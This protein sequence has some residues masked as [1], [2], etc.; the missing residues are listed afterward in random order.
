MLDRKLIRKDPDRVR[1]GLRKKGVA[2]DLDGFL[3]LDERQR[4]L[5][6]ETENLKHERNE[7]SQEISL[8]KKQ[9]RDS[10]TILERMKK[11]SDRIKEIDAE[12]KEI[13]A[14]LDELALFIPNL[15]HDSVPYGTC[16][17]QNVVR[18]QWGVVP[19]PSCEPLPHWDIGEKLGILDVA[20][21]SAL[22]GRGFVVLRGDGALLSR[23]LVNLMLDVHRSQGYTEM[24]VPYMVSR[25]CM[26]G[27]GQ[28]PKLAEDMY[29]SEKDDLF[30]IPTAEVPLTNLFRGCMLGGERFP[31]KV[32]AATPCFRREAGSYGQD[33][34]GLVRVH[35][36][37]KVEM[38]KLVFPETS[39]EELESLTL[40]ATAVLEA[41]E[42]PYRVLE[43]CTT[44]LSFGAA[45]CYDLETFAPGMGKWLEVSS[46]S[47]FEDFQA[48]RANIRFKR[49]P[50]EKPEFVHTLNGSGL[51]LPRI[52]A[53]ILELNQTPTGKV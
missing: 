25:D 52:I 32:T 10:S 36:F 24:C 4:S 49:R 42:L 41:L 12:L 23:A 8:L 1:E 15:P 6:Q 37:D 44:D 35:Q 13:S 19:E 17:E 27:T 14:R 2:F 34:K 48:R 11:T 51:A 46:C 26:I 29:L 53:T 39:Y 30:L 16:P 22:S 50:N 45:K 33:T 21:G 43:L 5:I 31:V 9:G 40:D 28:L 7:V 18:R 3:A 38:V 20:A 47:N